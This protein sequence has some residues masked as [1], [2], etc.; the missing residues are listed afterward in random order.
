MLSVGGGAEA[1]TVT[2]AFPDAVGAATLVA[3][4]IAVVVEVTVGAW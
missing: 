2:V 4:T 1:V 3:V